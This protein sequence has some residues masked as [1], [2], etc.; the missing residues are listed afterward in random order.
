MNTGPA[1]RDTVRK[2]Y[3]FALNHIGQDKD[4][5][6]IWT[7]YIQFLKAAEVR[8]GTSHS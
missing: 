3:E 6:E 7:D 1:T 2:A 5:T 4:S 8:T